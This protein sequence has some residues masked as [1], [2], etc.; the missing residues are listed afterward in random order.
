M[1]GAVSRVGLIAM[2]YGTLLGCGGGYGQ[3]PGTASLLE[4]TGSI[5]STGTDGQRM[6]ILRMDD[7]TSVGLV[8]ELQVELAM[9]SGAVVTVRGND[10][11]AAADRGLDVTE[12]EIVTVNGETPSVGMLERRGGEYWLVGDSDVHLTAVP[13]VLTQAVG[14]KIW[15]TGSSTAGLLRVQSFGI[16]RPN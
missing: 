13:A 2:T 7:G 8:G 1:M 16:I 4:I 10:A 5:T 12:Y 6:L 14:A 11:P 15:V 9:L 3:A